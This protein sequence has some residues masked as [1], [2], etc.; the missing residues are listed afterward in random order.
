M[1]ST[2]HKEWRN[3]H[4]SAVANP[5]EDTSVA[6]SVDA[7]PTT[8]SAAATTPSAA[9]VADDD[10]DVSSGVIDLSALRAG[11]HRAPHVLDVLPIFPFGEPPASTRAP[12]SARAPAAPAQGGSR[13]AWR[14][15]PAVALLAAAGAVTALT[16]GFAAPRAADPGPPA[17][18]GLAAATRSIEARLPR[19]EAPAAEPAERAQV[20]PAPPEAERAAAGVPGDDPGTVVAARRAPEG[21]ARVTGAPAPQHGNAGSATTGAADRRAPADPCRGDLMCAMRRATGG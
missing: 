19:A 14:A 16:V 7:Q 5:G 3:E 13:R 8:E 18:A 20:A 1:K 12:A 10:R 11:E 6:F 4:R 21:R 9:H 15:R 17:T 2:Q